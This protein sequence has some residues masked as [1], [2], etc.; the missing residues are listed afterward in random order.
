M[1]GLKLSFSLVDSHIFFFLMNVFTANVSSN[2]CFSYAPVFK[3][4]ALRVTCSWIFIISIA[5]LFFDLNY[6]IR[7]Q[8]L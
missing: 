7:F 5:I 4:D 2:D 6:S 3:C 1:P 8:I